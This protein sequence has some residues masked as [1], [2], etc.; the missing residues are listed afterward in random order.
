MKP[1]TYSLRVAVFASLLT[2]LLCPAAVAQQDSR[3]VGCW[4]FRYVD[5]TDGDPKRLVLKANGEA[6]WRGEGTY[7]ISKGNEVAIWKGGRY[8]EGR[9]Q[10]DHFSID[11]TDINNPSEILRFDGSRLRGW[12]YNEKGDSPNNIRYYGTKD[13][14]CAETAA[15]TPPA[16]VYAPQQPATVQQP[17]PGGTWSNAPAAPNAAGSGATAGAQQSSASDDDSEEEDAAAEVV[18]T[19][20]WT[21]DMPGGEHKAIYVRNNSK[22][23]TI[24]VTDLLVYDCQNMAI[25]F[26]GPTGVGVDIPPGGQSSIRIVGNDVTSGVKP[27][28]FKYKYWARFIDAP[29]RQRRPRRR[30]R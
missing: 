4:T 18:N 25:F 11:P 24:R 28:S 14:T 30:S 5:P 27:Y 7:W 13:A 2:F 21:E 19:S 9:P 1:K 23:R 12:Y 15:A 20:D 6:V 10:Y 17:Q 8:G 22:R 3:F 29:P 26:C 16:A